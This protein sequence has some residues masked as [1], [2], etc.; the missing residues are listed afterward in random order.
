MQFFHAHQ[1]LCQAALPDW[2]PLPH[3]DRRQVTIDVERFVAS[4]CRLLPWFIAMPMGMLQMAFFV[5]ASLSQ[6]GLP[7]KRQTQEQQQRFIKLWSKLG[8]PCQALL[9]LYR[10]LVML[11]YLEHPLIRTALQLPDQQKHQQQKRLE[12]KTLLHRM[13]HGD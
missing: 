11:A 1:A 8:K 4:E 13:Y 9:R 6:H 2:P 7:F 3:S 5:M 12:R 10:S